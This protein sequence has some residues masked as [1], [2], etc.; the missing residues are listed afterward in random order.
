[1]RKLFTLFSTAATAAVMSIPIVTSTAGAGPVAGCNPN[2][3]PC[4]P[5]AEDV[6]CLPGEG[7]G[8]AFIDYRVTVTG[9]DEYDL[10]RNGD[11]F[12]CDESTGTPP[13]QP[14]TTGPPTTVITSGPLKVLVPSAPPAVVTPGAPRFTG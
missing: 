14:P 10:D 6:D 1:M 2:Y 12:G 9:Q 8:P 5:N 3:D 7:N 4:V 11:G 13:T